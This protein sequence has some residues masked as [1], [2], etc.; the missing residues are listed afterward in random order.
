MI[1]H[2]HLD[3]INDVPTISA[4]TGAKLFCGNGIG[5]ML[6]TLHCPA[7]LSSPAK[8][9][10]SVPL[11]HTSAFLAVDSSVENFFWGGSVMSSTEPLKK[12]PF[13]TAM[14]FARMSP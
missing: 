8:I 5:R 14:L 9:Q 11:T 12:A 13:S 2:G 4:N 7:G 1:S 10:I 6:L 3:H